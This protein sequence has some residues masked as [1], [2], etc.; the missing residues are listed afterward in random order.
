[1]LNEE[2]VYKKDQSKVAIMGYDE[3]VRLSLYYS[4]IELMKEMEL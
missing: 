1:M 2:V 3:E 4:M